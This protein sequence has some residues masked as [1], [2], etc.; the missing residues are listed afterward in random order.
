MTIAD[1]AMAGR[2]AA[3]I[4]RWGRPAQLLRGTELRDCV[5]AVLDYTPH[6]AQM[7]LEGSKQALLAAPLAVEPDHEKDE[8]IFNGKKYA[9][10]AP[11]KGPRPADIPIYY[12]LSVIYRSAYP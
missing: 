11:V 2:C 12:D 1:E 3:M 6:A 10:V 8:L 4:A 9:I 5:A 7:A